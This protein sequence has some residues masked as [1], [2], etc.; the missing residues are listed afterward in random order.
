M[1]QQ[2]DPNTSATQVVQQSQVL[3][4]ILVYAN[5]NYFAPLQIQ[6]KLSGI[7]F[8]KYQDVV[9][10][11]LLYELFSGATTYKRLI[12][13]YDNTSITYI[14]VDDTNLSS[15]IDF[16]VISFDK[17][18]SIQQAQSIFIQFPTIYQKP[19][20]SLAI[21]KILKLNKVK[22]YEIM[23]HNQNTLKSFYIYN[24]KIIMLYDITLTP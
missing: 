17:V 14:L 9:R 11:F 12:Y 4:S 10:F 16:Q 8:Q 5:T 6:S 24:S 2:Q 3:Q 13:D 1:Y 18:T 19:D 23:M 20:P 21:I 7:S 22:Q 15:G